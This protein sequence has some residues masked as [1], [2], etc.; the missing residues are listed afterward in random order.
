MIVS[1]SIYI[2]ADSMPS[3]CD[4]LYIKMNG[5]GGACDVYGI[6]F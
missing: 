2:L 5:K 6:P 1:W 3:D 4:F